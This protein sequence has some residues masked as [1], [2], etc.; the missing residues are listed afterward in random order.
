VLFKTGCDLQLLL[1]AG[2][3][4]SLELLKCISTWGLLLRPKHIAM[5][6]LQGRSRL[7]F[8]CETVIVVKPVAHWASHNGVKALRD[9][10]EDWQG[11]FRRIF[12][13]L[14]VNF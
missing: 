12:N 7:R 10:L 1:P 4:G 3:N 13:C 5:S 2:E 11:L 14:N 6:L 9:V 8:A